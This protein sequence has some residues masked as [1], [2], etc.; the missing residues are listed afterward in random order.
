MSAT[1][2]SSLVPISVKLPPAIQAQLDA[3]TNL[4]VI[5]SVFPALLVPI[6]IALFFFSDST[7]RKKPIFILNVF[8]ITLGLAYGGLGIY[9]VV[10]VGH[11][12]PTKII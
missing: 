1:D 3:A 4:L 11:D 6:T 8:A 10:S 7:L 12:R 5:A 2:G 9:T